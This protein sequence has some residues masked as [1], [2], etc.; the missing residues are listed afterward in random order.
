MGGVSQAYARRWLFLHVDEGLRRHKVAL[1]KAVR[2]FME[3]AKARGVPTLYASADPDE[4]MA[5]KLMQSLGM[6]R[7]RYGK[8][9]WVWQR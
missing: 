7:L 4:P 5:E 9:L 3:D 8:G 2:R 6:E 1:V